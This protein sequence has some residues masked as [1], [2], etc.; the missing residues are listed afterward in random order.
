MVSQKR[1][2][3]VFHGSNVR[4]VLVRSAAP[5]KY[6]KRRIDAVP[7]SALMGR[8]SVTDGSTWLFPGR[9]PYGISAPGMN[10]AGLGSSY[11]AGD[12]I[13]EY[14]TVLHLRIA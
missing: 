7:T 1:V 2:G 14:A 12:S 6:G 3:G 13:S 11:Y 4:V 5:V 9:I 10:H 8:L